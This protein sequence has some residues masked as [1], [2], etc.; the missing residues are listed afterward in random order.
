MTRRPD[1]V[2]RRGFSLLELAIALAIIGLLAG[3][4][5]QLVTAFSAE[6]RLDVTRQ[7]LKAVEQALVRYA[8]RHGR[9][10]CPRD[11][12][13]MTVASVDDGIV[14]AGFGGGDPGRIQL[15]EGKT[16]DNTI[17]IS[18]TLD[19]SD[20]VSVEMSITLSNPGDNKPKTGTKT[21]QVDGTGDASSIA[22]EIGDAIES[23]GGSAFSKIDDVDENGTTLTLNPTG[24]WSLSS[25]SCDSGDGA[26]TCDGP[27]GG[28][29]T[30]T[31]MTIANGSD[32]SGTDPNW[33]DAAAACTRGSAYAGVPYRQLGIQKSAALD[34]W[35]RQITYVV[36]DGDAGM[37]RQ[38]GLNLSLAVAAEDSDPGKKD[39]SLT[40]S[41]LGSPTLQTDYLPFLQKWLTADADLTDSNQN[42][43]EAVGLRVSTDE[44]DTGPYSLD[45]VQGGGA[46]FVL[47]SHGP[48]GVGAFT[49]NGSQIV[50]GGV[51]FGD[52]EETNRDTAER[53]ANG[54][55]DSED[56]DDRTFIDRAR[57]E[58][59][60]GEHYDDIVRA[61]SV[62][63]L[64]R[65]AGWTP[66]AGR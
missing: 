6:Q 25:S 10:P 31:S 29:S 18:E 45:P 61:M 22:S 16:S 33:N 28:G 7:R 21:F 54:S 30:G 8:S 2:A 34:G 20:P 52:G 36:F 55:A 35:N 9:L 44:A 15:A 60:S 3:G 62:H 13:A 26:V 5:M 37:T 27:G 51:A 42:P 14:S 63:E 49:R 59:E 38:N 58:S 48:N 4:T 43:D 11:A 47:I 17:D 56:I 66:L 57:N 1:H 65:R 12:S 23:A 24:N 32:P 46:A 53:L 39:T 40:K 19:N 41:G 50:D 64:A